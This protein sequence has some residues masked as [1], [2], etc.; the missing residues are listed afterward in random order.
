M[1][2]TRK[3]E[4]PPILVRIG[5]QTTC[6]KY[7]NIFVDAG[8]RWGYH[9]KYVRRR[10]L[11]RVKLLKSAAGVSWGAHPSCLILLNN[12]IGLEKWLGLFYEYGKDTHAGFG[13]GS[14]PGIED[15]I[16]SDGIYTK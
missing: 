15:C 8:L 12:W 4:R 11:Q 10:C 2:F 5:P 1:L 14:V 7:L 6:L 9:A 16:G 13:K 3:H